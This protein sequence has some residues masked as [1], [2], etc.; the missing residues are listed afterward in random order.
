SRVERRCVQHRVLTACRARG[1]GRCPRRSDAVLLPPE[2]VFRDIT[3]SEVHAPPI[4]S[5]PAGSWSIQQL[6]GFLAMVSSAED[7]RTA[8]RVAVERAAEALGADVAALLRRGEVV[9]CAGPRHDPAIEAALAAVADGQSSR[10]M[11]PGVGDRPALA[12]T[13]EPDMPSRL[14]LARE[15]A[16]FSPEE[17]YL[18]RGMAH[19]LSLSLR[20]FR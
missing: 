12:I 3:S 17:V 14:V 10:L 9:A 6:T 8:S 11:G 15:G 4:P 7:E 5:G 2:H 20:L 16:D 1:R 13:V 18:A 19:V